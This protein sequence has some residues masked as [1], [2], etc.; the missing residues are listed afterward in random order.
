MKLNRWMVAGFVGLSMMSI[1]D[2]DAQYRRRTNPPAQQQQ[3][4]AQQQAGKPDTTGKGNLRDL[5]FNP[6]A[7]QQMQQQSAP[8]KYEYRDTALSLQTQVAQ[9]MR[10]NYAVDRNLIKDRKPLAYEHIREDDAFFSEFIWR[11]IDAREKANLSF[12]YPA[13]DDNGDQRFIA[14]LISAITKD[15]VLAFGDERF[16]T[17]I[18]TDKII[19]QLAG[20]LDTVPVSDPETGE[21]TFSI[22]RASS[23]NFDSIYTF[24]LK[25]QVIFDK[26]S[27]RL[28]FRIIGVCPVLKR[29]VG[30]KVSSFDLFWLY[31]P[32]LRPTLAKYEV[33]NSR[34]F[35]GRMTWEELFESRFFS[36]YITKTTWNNP[37]NL[38]LASLIKD[39]LFRL[40]EGENIKEKI[41]AFEQ[42]LWS[43]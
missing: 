36:S 1:I 18:S 35:S 3:Q 43:Y 13:I 31:Y 11:E 22:T 26:E 4:P 21:V 15:S 8:P 25:E 42:N 19:N 33:Y 17:P 2:A 39:P 30:N 27:S 12:R 9:S 23:V 29:K 38:P 6:P 24:R 10:N 32:D 20:K 28:Y 41:F 16:T 40:L 14:V 7:A 34:N 5:N 37:S